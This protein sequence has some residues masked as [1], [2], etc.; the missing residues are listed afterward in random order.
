VEGGVSRSKKNGGPRGLGEG[1]RGLFF[2]ELRNHSAARSL[3]LRKL[4]GPK[5]GECVGSM[6]RDILKGGGDYY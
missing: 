5:G 2:R 6:G 3:C 1:G 4:A